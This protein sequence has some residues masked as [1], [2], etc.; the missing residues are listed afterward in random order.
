MFHAWPTTCLTTCQ[1]AVPV[2][3]VVYAALLYQEWHA[4]LDRVP[5]ELVAP[6]R[7]RVQF[8]WTYGLGGG[9]C[10]VSMIGWLFLCDRF[11]DGLLQAVDSLQTL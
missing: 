3:F 11:A 10:G 1:S 4:P 6:F 9:R 5:D 7:Q 8:P 2:Q